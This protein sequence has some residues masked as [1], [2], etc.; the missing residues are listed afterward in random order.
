MPYQYLL[1]EIPRQSI[2][3]IIFINEESYTAI[4]SLA[5]N[6]HVRVEQSNFYKLRV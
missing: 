5:T 2:D 3:N 1:L 6:R 4:D